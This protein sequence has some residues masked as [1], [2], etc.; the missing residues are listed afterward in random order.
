MKPLSAKR[1][2]ELDFIHDEIALFTDLI[3]QVSERSEESV[4]VLSKPATVAL[5]RIIEKWNLAIGDLLVS[6]RDDEEQG[7]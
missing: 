3:G 5:Y 2:D 6:I 4:L 7:K 1:K